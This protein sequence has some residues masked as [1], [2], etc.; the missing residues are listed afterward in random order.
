MN[1]SGGVTSQDFSLVLA[2]PL[3]QLLRR[4][5][6]AGDAM[7]LLR[8]RLV[9]FSRVAWLPLSVLSTL[10]GQLLGGSAALPFLLDW[11][12]HVRFLVALPLM[13]SAELVLHRRLRFM[14]KQFHDR[15]LFP[16]TAVPRLDRVLASAL[17][18]RN[19][20][21][22]EALLLGI[23]YVGGIHFLWRHYTAFPITTWYGVPTA[24][25]VTLSH[26]GMWFVY[27]SLPLFQFLMIRWYYRVGIWMRFLWQ[28]S[29]IDLSLVPTHPDRVGGLGV[30][31]NSA[32]AFTALAAAHGALLSG[33]I[34]TRIFQL[35]AA[36]PDF[37]I[38]IAVYTVLMQGL[39][40]GPLLVFAPQLA[41]AKRASL[42][43]YGTLAERYVREFDAKWLR[44]AT[45]PN[46]PFVGSADIQFL[47]D[48]SNS[49]EVVRTMRI[50]PVTKNA[51]VSLA[52]TTLAPIAPLVRALMPMNELLKT[53][54]AILL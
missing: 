17:R 24:D 46:E 2:G 23:V 10:E 32:Y 51:I 13:I 41:R 25:D 53:V 38:E 37:T 40:F 9:V 5:H 4:L 31:S 20:V 42:R 35:G 45:P 34:A 54:F 44:R 39:V 14:V 16:E 7:A 30:L 18:L 15:N 50:A 49:F 8:W 48:L 26:S 28:V 47:A 22:A 1:E 36:L 29:R 19:S 43:D 11:E 21:L 6:L 12:T 33:W 52:A 27:V 3:F